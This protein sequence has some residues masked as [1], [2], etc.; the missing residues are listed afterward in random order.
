MRI[1]AR[2]AFLAC[3]AARLDL[4]EAGAMD[5]DEA[6]DDAFVERFR[7][8]AGIVCTCEREILIT[9]ERHDRALRDKR[10]RDWRWSR[11]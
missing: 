3:C 2:L 5:L 7:F 8:T 10:L 6:V 9:F 4:V 11:P 1:D